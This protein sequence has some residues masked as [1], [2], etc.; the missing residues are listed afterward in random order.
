MNQGLH[1]L[2]SGMGTVY[3]AISDWKE[4]WAIIHVHE[5]IAATELYIMNCVI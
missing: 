4:T 3:E 5:I 2:R 1:I